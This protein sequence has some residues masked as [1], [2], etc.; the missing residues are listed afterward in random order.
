MNLLNLKKR[1]ST[2]DIIIFDLDDTIYPQKNYDSPALLKISKFI[3]K[4]I[5]RNEILIFKKLRKIKKIRR[6]KAPKLLFNTFFKKL[7]ITNKRKII[8]KCVSMFQGY[9]CKE[10]KSSK[11]LKLLIS[12]L[13]KKKIL[14][15]VTNGNV[16]RQKKKIKYL[17]IKKYFKRIF[18]LD[19]LK[20]ATKPSI[21]S[22]KYLSRFIENKKK[23]KAVYVGDNINSDKKFAKNLKI[24]FIFYQFPSI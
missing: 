21:K 18:I 23:L 24:D 16:R 15:I 11:T 6:G 3:S 5:N 13:Y 4:K 9:E 10:L 14:F 8:F 7:K 20:T 22:V 1:L 19:G 2:Y 12:N 17:G